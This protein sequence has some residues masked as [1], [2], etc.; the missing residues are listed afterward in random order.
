[1]TGRDYELAL[2]DALMQAMASGVWELEG[3]A[4]A[5]NNTGVRPPQRSSWDAALLHEEMRR[6]GNKPVKKP[7]HGPLR[8][9]REVASELHGA[10]PQAASADF[11]QLVQRQLEL[12]I[13]NQWYCVAGSREVQ[14]K[15]FPITAL[16]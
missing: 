3:L 5:V 8:F 13:R 11:E 9:R 6:I 2:C 12:G 4:A 10:R 15:P 1:V 16:G 7:W 14:D